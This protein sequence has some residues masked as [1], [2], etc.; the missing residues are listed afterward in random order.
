MYACVHETGSGF[1]EG[2][3]GLGDRPLSYRPTPSFDS[4][5]DLYPVR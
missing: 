4:R 2:V 3:C 5:I 1:F